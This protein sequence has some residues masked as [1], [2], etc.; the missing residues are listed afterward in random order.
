M[1]F[2]A[3]ENENSKHEYEYIGIVRVHITYAC[4]SIY[5]ILA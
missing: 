3:F 5:I 2:L 4:T 1:Y